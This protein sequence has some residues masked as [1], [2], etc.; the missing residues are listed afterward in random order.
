MAASSAFRVREF[1]T[2][3]RFIQGYRYL[4]RCGEALVG[5]E[6]ALSEGWITT[7]TTPRA[8]SLKNDGLGMNLGFNSELMTVQ[9]NDAISFEHFLDQA[10]K[11]F[12]V[13]SNT[14]EI[15]RV[16]LPSLKVTYQKGFKDGELDEASKY[17][18]NLRL[19]GHLAC[20]WP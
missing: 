20:V 7:E 19:V 11:A 6:E 5:L 8:G 14:F 4:D 12:H 9:Q 13:L 2:S 1:L 17:L 15:K 18:L 16:H 3:I 10:C